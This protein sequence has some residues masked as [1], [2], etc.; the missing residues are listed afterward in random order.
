MKDGASAPDI[1]ERS[2][3]FALRIVKLCQCLDER[4]GVGR[5]LGRQVLRSGTSIGAN[6]EEANAAQSRADFTSKMMIALKEARE[7]VY[8]LRLLAAANVVPPER[9]AELRAESEELAKILGAIIVSTKRRSKLIAA[10]A[11]ALVVP[12]AVSIFHFSFFIFN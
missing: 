10:S 5:T 8:W 3:Q 9:L 6:A 2:F 11:L 4:P 12:L 7:T 1:Y